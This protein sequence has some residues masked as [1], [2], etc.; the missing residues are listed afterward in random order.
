ML[1]K[2]F[3]AKQYTSNFFVCQMSLPFSI[4]PKAIDLV[5]LSTTEKIGRRHS[6]DLPKLI[7]SP[8]ND[9]K[10]R[11]TRTNRNVP[12]YA[13]GSG[14]DRQL[15]GPRPISYTMCVQQITLQLRIR[16]R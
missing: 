2:A 9:S 6:T 13:V 12:P 10:Q 5:F 8:A 7:A 3:S 15:D 1:V 11:R 4:Y 16:S 14:S